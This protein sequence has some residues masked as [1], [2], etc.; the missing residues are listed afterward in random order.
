MNEATNPAAD[1]Q[2]SHTDDAAALTPA[3]LTPRRG[4]DL[5][6]LVAGL[7]SLGIAA[8]TLLGGVAWLPDVDGRWVLAA[9]ALL[10]GL[11]LVIGS[12]RSPQ[13]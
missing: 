10:V 8:T 9:L 3:A 1:P 4:P 12:L 6:T 5:L 11:L 7:G 13:H 2:P